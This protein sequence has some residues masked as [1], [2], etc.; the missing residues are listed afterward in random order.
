[1]AFIS[2]P[3]VDP[4]FPPPGGGNKQGLTIRDYFAAHA[5]AALCTSAG[6]ETGPDAVRAIAEQAYRLADAAVLAR[7]M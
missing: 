2:N 5:L 1:M 6:R 3:G 7:K 4:A